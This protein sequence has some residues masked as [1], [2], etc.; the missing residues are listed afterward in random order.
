M[1]SLT[2][3]FNVFFNADA[4]LNPFCIPFRARQGYGMWRTLYLLYLV[5]AFI[6]LFPFKRTKTAIQFVFYGETNRNE[7]K[8]HSPIQTAARRT[9]GCMGFH[10]GKVPPRWWSWLNA[11]TSKSDEHG[12]EKWEKEKSLNNQHLLFQLSDFYWLSEDKLTIFVFLPLPW[13]PPLWCYLRLY[14]RYSYCCYFVI[15]VF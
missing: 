13:P 8:I 2:Q 1:A 12:N 3:L 5:R 15:Y 7:S 6:Y 11:E 14:Y 4:V 10:H 9:S